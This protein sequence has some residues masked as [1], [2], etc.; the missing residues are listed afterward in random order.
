[1]SSRPRGAPLAPVAGDPAEQGRGG[2]LPDPCRILGDHGHARNQEGRERHV[3]EP[4]EGDPALKA[5]RVRRV[6]TA[7]Q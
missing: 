4:D 3:V 6:T 2:D 5:P 1:M 7:S